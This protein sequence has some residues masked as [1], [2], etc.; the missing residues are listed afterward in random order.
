MKAILQLEQRIMAELSEVQEIQDK[1]A[2]SRMVRNMGEVDFKAALMKEEDPYEPNMYKHLADDHCRGIQRTKF[3]RRNS[4]V[5]DKSSKGGYLHSN[6]H[7]NEDQAFS[8]SE[9]AISNNY[10]QIQHVEHGKSRPPGSK[11]P[12]HKPKP[13]N[14]SQSRG[15]LKPR[16]ENRRWSILDCEDEASYDST[17]FNKSHSRQSKVNLKVIP[18]ST[19]ASKLKIEKLSHSGMN[20]NRLPDFNKENESSKNLVSPAKRSSRVT[21]SGLKQ[22][23]VTSLMD[24]KKKEKGLVEYSFRPQLSS[25]SM[26]IAESLV[27]EVLLGSICFRTP[28]NGARQVEAVY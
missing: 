5:R 2:Q 1:L 18:N 17:T 14:S 28:D 3:Q 12:K 26:K 22:G 7:T 20:K 19:S 4:Q 25:K 23:S 13:G 6:R 11:T 10:E 15:V 24:S 8:P 16:R 9:Y 21:A 27:S